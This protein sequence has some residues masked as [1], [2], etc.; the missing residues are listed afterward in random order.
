MQP[1]T[2]QL[3]IAALLF[4]V[5]TTSFIVGNSLLEAA[6]ESPA[7]FQ[8]MRTQV[9][10]GGLLEIVNSLGVF[11]IAV[12]LFKTLWQHSQIVALSY[13]GFRLIETILLSIGTANALLPL[14][15]AGGTDFIGVL[16]VARAWHG[17]SFDIAMVFL[18]IGSLMLCHLMLRARLVP[19]W[20]AVLG[21]LGYGLLMTS[22]LLELIGAPENTLL[23]LPGAAFEIVFPIWLF[24]KGLST[25]TPQ[26]VKGYAR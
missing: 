10:L 3:R 8:T 17:L 19:A 26:P 20:L 25:P 13:L 15:L 22:V 4:L 9:L 14:Q 21:L 23:F 12:M 1:N 6:L 16:T 11:L 24:A 5:T 7:A 18:G 2:L